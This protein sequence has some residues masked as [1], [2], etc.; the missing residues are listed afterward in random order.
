[1]F[2]S[3]TFFQDSQKINI[4]GTR[5]YYKENS[6]K[7]ILFYHGNAGSACDR[8]FLRDEFQKL[9]YSYIF[10]EYTGYSNDSRKP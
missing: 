8:S 2:K 4:G 7:L 5:A 6:K 1:D 10:V 3:C 9:G